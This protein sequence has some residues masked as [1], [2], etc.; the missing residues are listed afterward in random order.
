MDK[1]AQ[2]QAA[3]AL[4]TEGVAQARLNAHRLRHQVE[5]TLRLV[6]ESEQKEHLYQLAGDMIVSVPKRLDDLEVALDRTA[7]ALSKMGVDFLEARLPFSDKALVDE[8][9]APA[10]GQSQFKHSVHKV[11]ARYLGKKRG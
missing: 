5:R 2:S 7:L 6:E 3:W 10:Y 1:K 4:L 9:L 11:V 8:T